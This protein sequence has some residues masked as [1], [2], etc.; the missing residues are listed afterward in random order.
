MADISKVAR[1]VNG[2]SRNIDT[3]TNTLV[4]DNLKIKL[5]GA[6][7]VTFSGS[8]SAIR[9]IT[10]PDANVNLGHIADLNTLTGVAGGATNLGTFTGETLDDNLS[11]KGALQALETAVEA[12][13]TDTDFADDAFRIS[14]NTDS[15]KKVGFDVAGL[16]TGSTRTIT[17]PDANVDLGLIATAIQSSEKGANNGVA[18]LD[19]GGK[20]PVSQLPNS[21]ME[22]QGEWNA[23][24]NTPTLAN[25][26][27]NAGDVYEVTA[28]GT[29]NFGAGAITFAVGDWAVYG[30]DGT[31]HKSL[32]SNE[33]TSVNG[34]AGTVVLDTDDIAEGST[35][36]YFSGKT[37]TDLPEG[38]NLYFTEARVLETDLAGLSLA[39]S[40]DI[41]SADTVLSALGKLQAQ[42][43][44]LVT[45][46]TVKAMVAGETMAANSTFLVRMAVNGETAGRAYKADVAAGAEGSETHHYYVI[47]MATT[48]GAIAAGQTISV[49]LVGERTIG[50]AET[51][52]A[53][54]DIGK[55][56]FL[57]SAGTMTLTAPSSANQAVVRVGTVMD[58]DKVMIQ[59]IQLMGIN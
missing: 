36:K 8:L 25:G 20:I 16:T 19:A 30:A 44:G 37:T 21:V 22:L 26:I 48:T 59:G 39:S 52:F 42:L 9:T 38:D 43:D 53:G 40:T 34:Q 18:T 23:S 33:V 15:T 17:V 49:T 4:V 3:S 31:W 56:V 7:H 14:D 54:A 45:D 1:L 29:V 10:V 47:G 58:T 35:N 41:T 24:T 28:A 57:G 11:I 50:S 2:V 6:N 46:T 5:G 51:P 12:A 27:G 32:N 13:V 55:P